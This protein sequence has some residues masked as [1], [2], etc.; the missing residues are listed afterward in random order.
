[1]FENVVTCVD[2]VEYSADDVQESV[3]LFDLFVSC[4]LF[5]GC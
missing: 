5:V 2:E 1:M 3:A 4:Q